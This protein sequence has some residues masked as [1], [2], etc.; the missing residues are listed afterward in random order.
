MDVP[1]HQKRGGYPTPPPSHGGKWGGGTPPPHPLTV[2]IQGGYPSPPSFGERVPS[3][4]HK[5]R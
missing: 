1:S 4:N 5:R 2:R 3:H